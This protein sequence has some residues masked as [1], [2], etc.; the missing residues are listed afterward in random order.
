[1]VWK[2]LYDVRTIIDV[3]V[4]GNYLLMYIHTHSTYYIHVVVDPLITQYSQTPLYP[5]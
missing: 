1:M 3:E 2:H 4:T 5:I